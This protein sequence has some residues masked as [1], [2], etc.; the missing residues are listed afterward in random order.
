V[1]GGRDCADPARRALVAKVALEGL[2]VGFVTGLVGAGGGF[3]V[4]PALVLLAG[5]P[6]AA[7]VGTSLVVIAMNSFAGLAGHLT[8]GQIDWRLAGMV[9]VAAVAGALLGARLTANVNADNLRAAFGWFVLA[10]A[11][12][13]LA[14]EIHPLVGLASAALTAVAGAMY[15][16][17]RLGIFCPLRALYP[18]G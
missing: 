17:C 18:G 4:V 13:I 10:M 3:L 1:A 2:A 16:T 5:L 6:M 15:L 14:Q 12:V 9:T 7:A 8:G 11:S